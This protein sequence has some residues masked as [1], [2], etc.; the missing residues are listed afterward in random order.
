M[1]RKAG[2]LPETFTCPCRVWRVGSGLS[3]KLTSLPRKPL[4]C[5]VFFIGPQHLPWAM[6]IRSVHSAVPHVAPAEIYRGV[7]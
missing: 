1:T 5:G 7:V 3:A 6:S 4:V 2:N